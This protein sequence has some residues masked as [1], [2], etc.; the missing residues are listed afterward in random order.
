MASSICQAEVVIGLDSFLCYTDGG[1]GKPA[2]GVRALPQAQAL[3]ADIHVLHSH[4]PNGAKGKKIV[5]PHGTPEHCF[6]L[7]SDGIKT[8]YAAGDSWGLVNYWIQRADIVCS[9]WPR[10]ADIY[11]TFAPKQNIKVIPMGVDKEF[12]AGGE[13]RGKWAGSPSVFNAENGHSIKW[14]LDVFLAWPFVADSMPDAIL[15]AHYL[16]FDMHRFWYPLLYLNGT[17]YKSFTSGNFISQGDLR[18]AFK[19]SDFYLSPVRYG[20]YNTICLEAKAAGSKV[21]SYRGNVY[22]DYWITEGDQRE[23]A[24]SLIE[25]FKGNVSPRQTDT[26]PDILDTAKAMKGIYEDLCK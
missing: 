9:F 20:D 10:H 16:P 18:N 14:P 24:H 13:S 8:N 21:I 4:I 2:P 1:V 5:I 15:H 23:M 17:A 26:I 11:R 22:A 7:S 25:I 6:Q 12:W 3:E 19:S